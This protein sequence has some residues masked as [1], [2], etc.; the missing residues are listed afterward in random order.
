[1]LLLSEVTFLFSTLLGDNLNLVVFYLLAVRF[2]HI[3]ECGFAKGNI[4]YLLCF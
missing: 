4:V 2:C 3:Q 1:M